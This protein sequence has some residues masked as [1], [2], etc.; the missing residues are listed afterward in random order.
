MGKT[1][2]AIKAANEIR[3]NSD[4]TAV[5]Y[6]N[7][8]YV[9]SLDDLAWKIAKQVYHFPLNEPISE[10]KRRLINEEELYTVLLLDNFERL[11]DLSAE[12]EQANIQ[13]ERRI[14]PNE[15]KEIKK[16][17][18]EVVKASTR[19]NLLITSS[20]NAVFPETGQQFIRLRPFKDEDSHQL[21]K[22]VYGDQTKVE[23]QT[24]YK[25][26]QLCGG[27]PLALTSLASWRDH[28]PDL[29]QMMTNANP[30]KRYEKFRKIPNADEDK[31]IDVCL[32]ACFNRLDAHLQEALISL[33]LFRGLF[34][35]TTA[36]DVFHSKE[37][38][39]QILEL[40]Q[41][42]F[43]EQNILDPAAPCWY[44]LLTVQKLYCQNKAQEAR[45]REGYNGARKLFIEHF[46]VFLEDTFEKFLSKDV[47]EAITAFR[48]QEENIMQLLDWFENGAMDEDEM[49]RCIDVFN[50]VGGLLAKMMGKRR[51]ETVFT[52][53]KKK[54]E[55]MGDRK[56]LSECLTSL[57]IREVFN[58]FFSPCLP[59]EA[60]ERA[61]DYLVEAE[62]IQT[63]LRIN[64]GNSRA[65]CLSKSGRCLAKGS[66]FRDAKEKIQ[67]AID[68]RQRRGDEDI[69]ML[70][71]TY[72][73]LAGE[74]SGL[75][76]TFCKRQFS[77]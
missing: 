30:K 21:L 6:L 13:S 32:D 60:A 9:R 27:I 34:S 16:F 72:N 46:C 41:L 63:A 70:G 17:I 74:F 54:S 22:K 71:A 53:L 66:R 14:D 2:T 1:I 24:A 28:P 52:L 12:T 55:D 18:T 69:V 67:Q 36:V 4:N 25:I 5:V 45:F 57:G 33:T 19:V 26:A 64:S 44:S 10:V 8:K 39:C 51:F 62:G 73:D 75:M 76:K 40:A 61:K 3:D 59:D 35:M 50:S 65:Q 29:V 37:L 11:R 48:Q 58:C 20:E 7:C 42:S 43:L 15:A 31:K 23:K 47:L 38:E 68:I 56:R 49:R 77:V